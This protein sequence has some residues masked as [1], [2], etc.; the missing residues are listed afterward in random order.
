MVD[1]DHTDQSGEKLRYVLAPGE[2]IISKTMI[3]V[4]YHWFLRKKSICASYEYVPFQEK[5][6]RD[7]LEVSVEGLAIMEL[8]ADRM[9]RFGGI[10]LLIDYG[11]EGT[12][13]DTFRVC[14]DLFKHRFI[15]Y[16]FSK[17]QENT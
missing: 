2:T 6:T 11:H 4:S 12:K 3:D 1:I 10:T 7:E 15:F 5:E 17:H 14:S 8:M 16:N 13:T 9:E